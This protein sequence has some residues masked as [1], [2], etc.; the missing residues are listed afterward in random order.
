M[1]AN[2]TIQV[3]RRRFFYLLPLIKDKQFNIHSLAQKMKILF[4]S[5]FYISFL[6]NRAAT[7]EL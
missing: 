7:Y 3:K 5:S 2:F 1:R 4:L 6:S